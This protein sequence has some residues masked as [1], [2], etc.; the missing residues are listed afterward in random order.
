MAR[1]NNIR[2]TR[3][4]NKLNEMA[5][6]VFKS[7]EYRHFFSIS[8][9]R[10][11]A[12]YY[13]LER[14]HF[15]LNR[16]QCWALVQSK[17]PF[18]VK[19]LIWDHEREELAGDIERGVEN[20]WVLGMKEGLTVGLKSRDFKGPPSDITKVCTYAWAHIA[21]TVPWLEAISASGILEIDN[22]DEDVSYTHMTLQKICSV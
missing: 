22:S 17:A 19:Q 9:T 1:G 18:D 10:E 7:N 2:L 15:H 20:H 21:E 13:I 4:R 16:R 12:A 8:L 14:S 3:L 11:R 5:N 6:D